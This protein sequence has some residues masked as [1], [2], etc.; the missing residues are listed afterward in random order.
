[1][2]SLFLQIKNLTEQLSRLTEE[3]MQKLKQK[4]ERN[5]NKKVLKKK[6]SKVKED[7]KS[8]DNDISATPVS[9]VVSNVPPIVD[10]T[11]PSKTPKNKANKKSPSESKRKKITNRTLSST[12]KSKA[13]S[14]AVG[15]LPGSSTFDSDDEDNAKPMT[16][17]EKRQL[18]LDINKLPGDKLGRVVYIIQSREPSLRDSNPDEIEIDF[19][20]LKPSTLREL[21]SYVMSCLKK[22]KRKPYTKKATGK[23]REEAQKE[24]KLELEK[25]LND[26]Q[27]QLGSAKKPSKKEESGNVDVVGGSTRLSASSSS[28]SGSD[29]SSDSSSSSSSDSSDSESGSPVKKAKGKK[30]QKS[31]LTK[32]SA[33]KKK[34]P[35]LRSQA[36]SPNMKI[37]IGGNNTVMVSPQPQ[38]HPLPPLAQ[39]SAIPPQ[40]PP[41][42]VPDTSSLPHSGLPNTAIPSAVHPGLN[43][44]PGHHMSVIQP[45]PNSPAR[46]PAVPNNAVSAKPVQISPP[47][48]VNSPMEKILPESRPI[49]PPPIPMSDEGRLNLAPREQQQTKF[50]ISDDDSSNS[51]KASPNKIAPP[52]PPGA[53]ILASGV[54]V[55]YSGNNIHQNGPS[56]DMMRKNDLGKLPPQLNRKDAAV[57]PLKNAASWSSL[58]AGSSTTSVKKPNAMQSFELFKKQAKEKEEREKALKEQEEQRK[59]QKE[60]MERERQRKERERMRER[61]EEEA[62]YSAQQAQQEAERKRLQ[63]EQESKMAM[64]ERER[65]REQERRKREAMAN[66]IDMNAQSDLMASFEET[67]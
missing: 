49:S 25:M 38:L 51:P 43:A 13:S 41:Y 63:A 14:S 19:E 40:Q 33:E 32:N 4:K 48:S 47:I 6:K 17:D 59:I 61:E 21:E 16:Y 30:S 26:V 12:K 36:M 9:S 35:E 39:A 57:K 3:H 5:E 7:I 64:K 10:T 22:N 37:H 50:F 11:K 44:E 52:A 8:R 66:A 2:F 67:L 18:S 58:A 60:H 42:N 15:T 27:G 56:N 31:K 28:S 65:R 46:V 24:K 29:S 1:M 54:G 34:S 23:S 20:T 45:K 55:M 62:L 53:T